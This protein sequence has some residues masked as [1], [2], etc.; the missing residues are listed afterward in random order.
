MNFFIKNGNIL[1][2]ILL[3]LINVVLILWVFYY[4]P[5]DYE[6]DAA[7]TLET[8]K[9]IYHTIFTNEAVSPSWS[10]RAPLYKLI[11][12]VSGTF[13]FD[14]FKPI[15][16]TQIIFSILMPSFFY[17]T[18]FHINRRF[19][20][21]GSIIFILSLIPIIHLKLILSVHSMIFFLVLSNFFLVKFVYKK[22]IS[23]FYFAFITSLMVMMTRF[24]GTFIFLGQALILSYYLFKTKL[25]IKLK[26]KHLLKAYSVVVITMLFWMTL[27]ATFILK[28]SNPVQFIQSFASLNHQSGAQLY[29]SVNNG[30]RN[31]INT[32]YSNQIGSDRYIDNLLVL[33]NGP[34]SKKL[35]NYLTKFFEK[36]GIIDHLSFFEDK[37]LPISIIEKKENSPSKI[38]YDHFEKFF[39]DPKK[40]ADNVFNEEFESYHY[41]LIIP[42]LLETFYGKSI[43]DK[44]LLGASYEIILSNKDIKDMILKKYY[45]AYGSLNKLIFLRTLKYPNPKKNNSWYNLETF[46][47]ANCASNSLSPKMFDEYEN[48]Y[49]K[50]SNKPNSNLIEKISSTH[51]HIIRNFV[52][53]LILIFLI[54]IFFTKYFFLVLVLFASYN[55]T[56]IFMSV[57]ASGVVHRKSE[58]YTLVLGIL[59][60]IFLLSGFK[61]FLK[62]SFK[63]LK[64]NK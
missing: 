60:L 34:A 62:W 7:N 48:Q 22:N 21:L 24:D 6:C 51:R 63:I 35:Y 54:F 55:V 14:S 13:F 12:I 3:Q 8:S 25:E 23:D 47:S 19:A 41:P 46:D 26:L 37:M 50:N 52:G 45:D 9:Y 1:D 31:D 5:I 10:Y 44:L 40:I 28:V 57:M 20:L 43:T 38:Y 36:E 39:D 29:W 2:N 17:F 4:S 16:F 58:A 32:K 49:N 30:M 15:V 42:A 11:Q 18:L 61:N 27:K 64:I 56:L 33:S 59:I 53:P